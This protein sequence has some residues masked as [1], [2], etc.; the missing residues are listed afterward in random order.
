MV[1]I[2]GGAAFALVVALALRT[3]S[4]RETARDDR[5]AA[6]D[7]RPQT[8]K[9]DPGPRLD[10][11]SFR[12][13]RNRVE[14]TN[15]DG[16][17]SVWWALEPGSALA[18]GA[19]GRFVVTGET[20]AM[21]DDTG[22]P[23]PINDPRNGGLGGFGWH[24]ARRGGCCD[25]APSYFASVDQPGRA[26]IDSDHAWGIDSRARAPFGVAGI[27]HTEP[28]RNERGDVTFDVTLEYS[29]GWH[30][31]VLA[32]LYHYEFYDGSG[33][34]G[35]GVRVWMEVEQLCGTQCK[36]SGGRRFAS[37]FVKEPKLVASLQPGSDGAIRYPHVTVFD[38]SSS[39]EVISQC[40]IGNLRDAAEPRS[41]CRVTRAL[42]ERGATRV[43][44]DDGLDGCEQRECFHASFRSYPDGQAP[45]ASRSFR[46]ADPR[47]GLFGWAV[48]SDERDCF[49]LWGGERSTDT[50]PEGDPAARCNPVVDTATEEDTSGGCVNLEDEAGLPRQ[51]ELHRRGGW[52]QALV[53]GWTGGHGG[54]DCPVSSRAF[55]PEGEV[56]SLYVN[57]SYGPGWDLQE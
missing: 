33:P 40:N 3:V 9:G 36:Q 34:L 32:L 25:T 27:T 43:R 19:I 7:S 23:G 5:A 16:T 22:P 56:W 14:V 28:S 1:S 50:D 12:T 44:F 8:P 30:D 48:S 55:G 39:A 31:P 17:W 41:S 4:D 35:G 10:G 37:V 53:P 24:H 13:F 15:S 52:A 18:P 20:D 45:H 21:V 47:Y 38:D 11:P 29:D 49:G 57:Y 6:N 46:W 2:L 42:L 26:D 54:Y 51:W